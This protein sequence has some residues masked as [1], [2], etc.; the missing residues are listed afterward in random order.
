MKSVHLGPLCIIIHCFL[1]IFKM[2]L[3]WKW[4]I[5][6]FSSQNGMCIN[7]ELRCYLNYTCKNDIKFVA[8]IHVIHC[9]VE[10]N[11]FYFS[12]LKQASTKQ[13][14]RLSHFTKNI[15]VF[16]YVLKVKIIHNHDLAPESRWHPTN[17]E[18]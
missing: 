4:L 9:S 6:S 2:C 13:K 7:S 15:N 18:K 5:F 16:S 12:I 11:E 10:Y 17:S 1:K 8:R 14:L 3:T